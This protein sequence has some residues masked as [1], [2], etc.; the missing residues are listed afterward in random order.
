MK[1]DISIEIPPEELVQVMQGSSEIALKIQKQVADEVVREM[2]RRQSEQLMNAIPGLNL[3]SP[4]LVP[5]TEIPNLFIGPGL[6][7]AFDTTLNS[8]NLLAQRG[9][10]SLAQENE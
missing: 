2:V 10:Q 8:L 7:P 5:G 9:S 6:L 4:S 1:I 3:P